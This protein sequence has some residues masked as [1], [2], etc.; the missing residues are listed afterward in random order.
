[1]K[2][3]MWRWNRA[4]WPVWGGNAENNHYSALSQINRDNVKQLTMA[5][6]FDSQEEGGLQTSP[7]VVEGVLYGITPTE[8][9]FALDA[10]T[11][12]LFWKFDSGVR[13]TQP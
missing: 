8:K 6:S 3:G 4:T 1:M 10:A 9:I 13:G 5:W 2:V 11:G 12:K 7:I